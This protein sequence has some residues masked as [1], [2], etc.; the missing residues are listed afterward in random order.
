MFCYPPFWLFEPKFGYPGFS[1]RH[2]LDLVSASSKT[3]RRFTLGAISI[4]ED[5][6]QSYNGMYITYASVDGRPQPKR[7]STIYNGIIRTVDGD[8]WRSRKGTPYKSKS[9][10]IPPE[11]TESSPIDRVNSCVAI[12]NSDTGFKKFEVAEEL[13]GS[14]LF[15]RCEEA[16][17]EKT[18]DEREVNVPTIFR[19]KIIDLAP[20][21]SRPKRT[22][23]APQTAFS[24]EGEHTPYII[25]KRL[26][27][28]SQADKF[29]TFLRSF[30]ED[31]GLFESVDI[32]SYGKS[33]LAP[34]EVK[35]TLGQ[36]SL[37]LDNVGYGVSQALPVIVDIFIRPKQTTF[38]VQQPEVHLHPKAQATIGDL[39]AELARDE[40]K[41]FFIETHS[42]FTIDRYRLNIRQ[43]GAI[44]SQLLF[45][46]RLGGYN[47]ATSIHIDENGSLPDNQPESYRAFF[48]NESLSLLG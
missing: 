30:G 38:T 37:G 47:T 13:Q 29:A 40:E 35:I 21:R 24:P 34:F 14:P 33:P 23:D 5:K 39:I 36:T 4:S 6:K 45:F 9:Q 32:K 17:F 1:N 19:N 25:K 11:I 3:K 22:Y 26:S 8:L 18:G 20:I 43:N 48:F 12:H 27:S 31:S 41:Q 10:K 42:D 28:K 46:E 15:I 44:P 16:L 7:V 2:F